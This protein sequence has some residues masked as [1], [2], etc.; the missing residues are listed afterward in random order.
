MV[1]SSSREAQGNDL[2]RVG[3]VGYV[4]SSDRLYEVL[5]ERSNTLCIHNIYLHIVSQYMGPY[6]EYMYSLIRH[7]IWIPRP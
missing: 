2:T 1:P 6:S 4:G 3:P 7:V 5:N